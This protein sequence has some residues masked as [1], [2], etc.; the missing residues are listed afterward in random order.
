MLIFITTWVIAGIIAFI[1][2]IFDWFIERISFTVNDL[3]IGLLLI[4]FGYF[5][6]ISLLIIL[7]MDLNKRILFTK[8]K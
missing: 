1:L 7:I 4:L 5:S 3:K 2:F 8:N 6:F